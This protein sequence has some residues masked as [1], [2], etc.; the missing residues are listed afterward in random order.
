MK[1]HY[2]YKKFYNKEFRARL[3][4]N[5]ETAIRELTDESIANNLYDKSISI[6]KAMQYKVVKSA[7]DTTYFIIPYI[8]DSQ[9]LNLQQVNAGL[10]NA[11]TAFCVSTLGSLGTESSTVGSFSSTSTLGSASSVTNDKKDW[12]S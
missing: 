6:N 5:D 10:D 11:S 12:V 1:K 4:R 2:I 7:K 9:Y 3:L 8:K